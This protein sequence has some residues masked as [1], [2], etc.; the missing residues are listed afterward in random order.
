MMATLAPSAAYRARVPPQPDSGSS[1]WPPTQTIFVVW[2]PEVWPAARA[3]KERNWRREGVMA[4]SPWRSLRH[5]IVRSREST[6][7]ASVTYHEQM[8]VVLRID[9]A[10]WVT[11][12]AGWRTGCR[13]R[14]W[15]TPRRSH[16]SRDCS[17][18]IQIH[19]DGPLRTS[20]SRPRYACSYW[21]WYFDN[22]TR[23][24]SGEAGLLVVRSD[25][26]AVAS[27]Q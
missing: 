7:P 20:A 10:V 4:D 21:F 9:L 6:I 27:S 16:L 1:G 8:S 11:R 23:Y 5:G 14:C 13:P 15:R 3:G 19:S 26:H 12:P 25:G 17:R 18:T 2:P 24:C 22:S